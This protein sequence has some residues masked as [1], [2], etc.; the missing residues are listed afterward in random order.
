[1]S[2]HAEDIQA[3][4]KTYVVVFAV[5]AALT[6]ITVAISYLDLS[7]PMAIA[8]ALLVATTKAGLVALFFMHLIDEK[9][10]IYALLALA[11]VFFAMCMSIPTE[12]RLGQVKSSSVWS[13]IETGSAA[14][15]HETGGHGDH[16]HGDHDHGDSDHGDSGHGDHGG[17]H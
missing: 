2:A 7:T 10:I 8:V 5:L 1:M 6:V 13:S 12:W 4:V 11:A 3:H 14:G 17:G 9:K 15:G 16:D